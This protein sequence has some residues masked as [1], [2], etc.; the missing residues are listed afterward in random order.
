VLAVIVTITRR[1]M[2]SVSNYCDNNDNNGTYG[3]VYM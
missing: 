3:E 2:C 1:F